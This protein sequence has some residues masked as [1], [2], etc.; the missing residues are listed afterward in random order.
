MIN[1][2]YIENKMPDIGLYDLMTDKNFDWYY[3]DNTLGSNF[4]SSISNIESNL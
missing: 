1:F 3:N 2:N 4:E